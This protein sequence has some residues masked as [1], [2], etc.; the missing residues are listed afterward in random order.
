MQALD[1]T[2][3]AN[4]VTCLS[5]FVLQI[6]PTFLEAAYEAE[7]N[8]KH[9]INLLNEAVNAIFMSTDACPL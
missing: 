9:L 6:N 3:C 4:S 8:A 2:S 5:S 7:L 1:L